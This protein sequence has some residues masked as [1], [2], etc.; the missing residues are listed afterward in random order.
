MI[1]AYAADGV[2]K[3]GQWDDATSTFSTLN[4]DGTVAVS[5][6]YTAT[7]TTQAQARAADAAAEQAELNRRTD[8]ANF[9]SQVAGAQ[10]QA[11]ADYNAWPTAD[12]PT[13]DLIVQRILAGEA[14]I[15]QSLQDL[16]E[17]LGVT[18]PPTP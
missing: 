15:A 8:L 5:R 14:H 6:P 11:W 4:A 13:R 1:Y 9:Y 17:H 3:I 7:E 2:T 16:A 18:K 10:S 12:Q